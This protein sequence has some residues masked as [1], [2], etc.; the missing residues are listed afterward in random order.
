[1]QQLATPLAVSG[2]RSE[3]ASQRLQSD[4]DAAGFSVRAYAAGRVARPK[5]NA[6]P[7]AR[8]QAGGNFAAVLSYGD[9]TAAGFGTTTF[10]VR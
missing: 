7:T 4:L 3:S 6:V 5:A 1:M 9:F 10:G 8:P 2:D